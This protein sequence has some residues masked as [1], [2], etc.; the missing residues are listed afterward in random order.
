MVFARNISSN[1]YLATLAL[2]DMLICLT[3]ILLFGV[4][5]AIVY[6]RDVV[7]LLKQKINKYRFQTLFQLYFRYIL[8]TLFLA[9]VVQFAIPYMLILITFERYLWTAREKTRY[10]LFFIPKMTRDNSS[11]FPLSIFGVF[12]HTCS[13]FLP[14]S[15]RRVTTQLLPNF[16]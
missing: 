8:P 4:D 2:L 15:N 6:L 9:K 7:F 3:Y 12:P 13:L 5:A 14:D 1:V 16:I 10:F 11:Q